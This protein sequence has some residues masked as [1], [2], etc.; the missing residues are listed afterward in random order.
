M[1]LAVKENVEVCTRKKNR[2][3]NYLAHEWLWKK[4]KFYSNWLL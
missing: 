4:G 1:E 3:I 2:K